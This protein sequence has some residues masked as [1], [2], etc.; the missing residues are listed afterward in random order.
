[1]QWHARKLLGRRPKL[2]RYSLYA[3]QIR[4]LIYTS[5]LLN[6]V[7]VIWEPH[8]RCRNRLT[9]YNS[10]L[11]K[12]TTNKFILRLYL[13]TS[14]NSHG[15]RLNTEF[16]KL[17]RGNITLF[18]KH[19]LERPVSSRKYQSVK[20]YIYIEAFHGPMSP[21]CPL[22]LFYEANHSLINEILHIRYMSLPSENACIPV[23]PV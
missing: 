17:S 8:K 21:I 10:N 1:M 5:C 3:G 20:I 14:V 22:Q 9:H 16:L 19:V 13:E 18:T 12:P 7:N 15:I 6:K 4:C 11:A 23:Q 2:N